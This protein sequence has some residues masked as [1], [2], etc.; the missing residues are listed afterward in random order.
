MDT[1]FAVLEAAKCG[2]GSPRRISPEADFQ[3][4]GVMFSETFAGG[5]VRMV[6]EK[7]RHLPNP[8]A[9]YGHNAG[10]CTRT[11]RIWR[12]V[13]DLLARLEGVD[14]RQTSP[15]RP[16]VPFLLPYGQEWMASEEVLSRTLPGINPTMIVRA[17]GLDQGNIILNLADVEQRGRT[18]GTLF[19]AGSAI[20]SIKNAAGKVDPRLGS[21]AMMQAID[22]HRSGELRD[23]PM[24]DHLKALIAVA[25]RRG[26]KALREA[27]R[28]RYLS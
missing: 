12:E 9:I 13:I 8:P 2:T 21:E 27:L 7:T 6:R 3:P 23:V 1:V 16:G 28:Q 5:T 26:L 15:V 18:E 17:G 25:D 20:N 22:V 11:P 10:I 24:D 4:V 19:L 14:F